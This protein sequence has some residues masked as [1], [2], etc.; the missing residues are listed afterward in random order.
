MPKNT[1]AF[2]R[3]RITVSETRMMKVLGIRFGL[4]FSVSLRL[5]LRRLY[6]DLTSG[7]VMKLPPDMK[8]RR[9]KRPAETPRGGEPD[10][11]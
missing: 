7:V 9:I 8:G 3:Q 11:Q 6:A 10:G 2:Y 1:L 4:P 5:A